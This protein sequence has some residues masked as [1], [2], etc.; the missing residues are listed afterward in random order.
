[1]N[2]RRH[3][4]GIQIAGGGNDGRHSGA[5]I[6]SLDHR[7]VADPNATDVGDGVVETRGKYA[8]HQPYIPGPRPFGNVVLSGAGPCRDQ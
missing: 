8:D 7:C 3:G 2:A 4:I 5:N 1:M 6:V